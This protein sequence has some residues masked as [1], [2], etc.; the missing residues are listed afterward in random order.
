MGNK[1]DTLATGDEL[2]ILFNLIDRDIKLSYPIY[3]Q[4][5]IL[6]ARPTKKGYKLKFTSEAKDYRKKSKEF[7][8]YSREMPSF[9][10]FKDCLLTSG[11]ISHVYPDDFEERVN[12]ELKNR[13]KKVLFCPDTNLFYQK[14]LSSFEGIESQNVGIVE[15]VKDE[16]ENKMN[17]KYSST[18]IKGMKL[19]ASYKENLLDELRNRRKKDSRKAKYLA[20]EEY[21]K[22]SGR[23]IPASKESSYDSEENDKIIVKSLREEEKRNPVE[24]ILLTADEQMRDLCDVENVECE[25]LKHPYE[26]DAERCSHEDFVE[27]V[28]NI[29]LVF[30]FVKL[31]SVILFG[32]FGGKS[33]P[34]KLKIRFLNDDTGKEF[35]KHQ[36]IC[37]DLSELEVEK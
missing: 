14:F 26:F 32:E 21:R 5:E 30:G 34:E 19:Y 13:N 37:R 17:S 15:T 24:T 9:Y 18:D 27:L 25:Y 3:P 36:K 33:D 31:N 23:I 4:F 1:N 35:E 10:D 6:R 16:L 28:K 11:V 20:L 12:R 29:A 7:E 22:F 8:K 2:Q